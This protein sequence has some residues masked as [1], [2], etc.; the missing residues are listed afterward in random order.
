M[1]GCVLS[2]SAYTLIG[3]QLLK[4][5]EPLV[6]VA[7]SCTVGAIFL[8]ERGATLY[9]ETYPPR[10]TVFSVCCVVHFIHRCDASRKA[11]LRK[12]C[13]RPRGNRFG[14]C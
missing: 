11:R 5:I 8:V 10:V 6:A 13:E 3:K 14:S 12:A 9:P 2:W 4:D 1:V 7:Y